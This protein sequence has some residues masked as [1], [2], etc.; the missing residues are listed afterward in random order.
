MKI[1]SL[2]DRGVHIYDFDHKSKVV[3][4]VRIIRGKV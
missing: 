1:K 3:R 4:Q 2:E